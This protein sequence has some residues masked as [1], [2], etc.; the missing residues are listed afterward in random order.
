MKVGSALYLLD[1]TTII[2]PIHFPSSGWG[3]RVKRKNVKFLSTIVSDLARGFY[4]V[5]NP[6]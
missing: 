1:K 3:Y 2:I 5:D 4:E 6:H